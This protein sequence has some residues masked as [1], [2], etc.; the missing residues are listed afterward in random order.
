MKFIICFF[1]IFS[2]FIIFKVPKEKVV[3][4]L[5]QTDKHL[6][7]ASQSVSVI[8]LT[9]FYI[10]SDPFLPGIVYLLIFFDV[11]VALWVTI[12]RAHYLSTIRNLP[13]VSFKIVSFLYMIYFGLN[14]FL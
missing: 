3:F 4:S 1:Y 5:N 13:P 8:L 14:L 7:L 11:T 6:M 12:N 10:F 2:G 9:V